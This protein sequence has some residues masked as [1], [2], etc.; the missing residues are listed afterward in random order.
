MIQG[1]A[2]RQSREFVTFGRVLSP[3]MTHDRTQR[4]QLLA[5]WRGQARWRALRARCPPP[6]GG[7]AGFLLLKPEVFDPAFLRPGTTPAAFVADIL[8][9]VESLGGRCLRRIPLRGTGRLAERLWEG[10]FRL[11]EAEGDGEARGFLKAHFEG[12]DLELVVL[13][14][15]DAWLG[16]S[17]APTPWRALHELRGENPWREDPEATAPED[18][19]TVREVGL[20]HLRPSTD[21]RHGLMID[22]VHACSPTGPHAF[23]L[24]GGVFTSPFTNLDACLAEAVDPE[25]RRAVAL[26][27]A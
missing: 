6:Q 3:L 24:Q 16:Q 27:T 13:W 1:K 12:A 8:G 23:E 26:G 11:R 25:D 22:T 7:E 5:H 20:R 2:A 19:R 9:L 4:R 17:A 18:P 21:R 10:F 14:L 15:P